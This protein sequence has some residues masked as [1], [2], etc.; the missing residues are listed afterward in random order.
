MYVVKLLGLA[1]VVIGTAAVCKEGSARLFG[2][3]GT[4]AKSD[5]GGLTRF[6]F[7]DCFLTL[8]LAKNP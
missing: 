5:L 4:Y 3:L 8:G 6:E 2:D 1:S 7:K